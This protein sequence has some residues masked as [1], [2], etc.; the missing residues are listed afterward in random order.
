[1]LT[2]VRSAL[3]APLALLAIAG[4]SSKHDDGGDPADAAVDGPVASLCASDTRAQPFVA[5]M[6]QAGAAGLIKARL[7][8]STPAPPA[9]GNNTWTVQIVDAAGAPMDGATLAVK[10][11]MPD[12]GHGTSTKPA[13]K[14]TGDGKYEV[15]L[16]SLAMPGIWQ[17][18][19]TVTTPSSTTDAAVFTF[20]VAG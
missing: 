13:I 2:F 10:G 16:L 4:C 6:E 5:G 20:C 12:H 9:R 3:V 1:M 8:A 18:T 14:G 19:I 11:Y 15:D 7:L 17:I